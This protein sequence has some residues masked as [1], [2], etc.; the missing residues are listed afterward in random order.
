MFGGGGARRILSNA[1]PPGSLARRL[2]D[3]GS[4]AQ[5]ACRN[6]GQVNVSEFAALMAALARGD[7]TPDEAQAVAI[8]LEQHRRVLETA[9]PPEFTR[10]P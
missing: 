5:K 6:S 1:L 3:L 9:V 2:H 8:L 10:R 4:R 7:L